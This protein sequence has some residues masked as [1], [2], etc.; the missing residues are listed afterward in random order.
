MDGP[1][2][3]RSRPRGRVTHSRRPVMRLVV[4]LAA[5]ALL[6]ASPFFLMQASAYMSHNTAALYIL[7]SLLFILKRDRPLLYG[8]LAGVFFGLLANT[9]PLTAA[10]LVPPYGALIVSYM[11]PRVHRKR[12]FHYALAFGAGALSMGVAMLLYNWG[13][14][15]DPLTSA[16]ASNDGATF[17]FVKG[18]TLEGGLKNQQAQM[19]ALLAVFNGWPRWAGLVLVL[20]PFLLGTRNRWDYLLAVIALC[21]MGG[22]TLYKFSGLYEGPRYWY[23][24]APFLY[25]LAARGIERAAVVLATAV[26]W[27]RG[28]VVRPREPHSNLTASRLVVY[29]AVV[30]LCVWGTG[31]WVIGWDP[32]WSEVNGHNLPAQ[33]ADIKGIFGPDDR[34]VRLAERVQLHNALVL[35]KPCGYFVSNNCYGTVFLRNNL[36]FNGDVVWADWVPELNESLIKAYPGR[37]VYVASWDGGA[38]IEPYVP[39]GKPGAPVSPQASGRP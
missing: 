26:T 35:V 14:T 23:E 18:H 32:G 29:A 1:G 28:Y 9:R 7:L 37:K 3:R 12:N 6:A 4:P 31:N 33:A 27:L 11:A 2:I 20:L 21:A 30:A 19:M 39:P 13:L 38:T 36:N 17:G 25:L 22:Y 15:G 5:V 10:S 16:Y 34:M 8:A 24:A